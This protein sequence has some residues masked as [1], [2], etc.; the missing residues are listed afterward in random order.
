MTSGVKDF[1]FWG[2]NNST[3]FET[4]TNGTDT[5][6]TQL[7]CDAT[8]FDSHVASNVADPKYSVVTNT[9]AYRYYAF[10]FANNWGGLGTGFMSLR[11]VVLQTYE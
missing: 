3:A 8:Q 7:T 5:D 1:T 2:S 6:W 9:T 10:K 11:R 4:L